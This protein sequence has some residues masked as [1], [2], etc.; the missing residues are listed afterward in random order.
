MADGTRH[1]II[2]SDAEETPLAAARNSAARRRS[3]W[4][5]RALSGRIAVLMWM[6]RL[7]VA[8]MVAV[9]AVQLTRLI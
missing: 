5:R 2:E 3:A 4:P 7:Y 6:M 8:A 9:I 1:V